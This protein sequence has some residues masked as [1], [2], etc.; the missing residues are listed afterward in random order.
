MNM[1][2]YKPVYEDQYDLDAQVIYAFNDVVGITCDED[3]A[4]D[5]VDD[6]AG[7]H[8]DAADAGYGRATNA[9]VAHYI[10]CMGC[11]TSVASN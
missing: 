11:G 7:D 8:G 10:T 4:R 9:Q 3:C 2:E 1:N 5:V 6:I